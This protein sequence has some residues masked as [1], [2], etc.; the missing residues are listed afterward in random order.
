MVTREKE[1]RQLCTIQTTTMTTLP[2]SCGMRERGEE[3]AEQIMKTAAEVATGKL[4]ASAS[5][6]CLNFI[7]VRR[8]PTGEAIEA[9]V[10]TKW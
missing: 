6:L 8:Q 3:S 1:N 10:T 2:Y 7:N 5:R 4:N 9:K